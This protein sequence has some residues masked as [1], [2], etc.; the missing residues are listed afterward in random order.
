ME[1]IKK[2]H[3]ELRDISQCILYICTLYKEKWE[4]RKSNTPSPQIA[5]FCN[6]N[7]GGPER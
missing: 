5:V 1:G 4:P 3:R 7:V 6:F 2:I